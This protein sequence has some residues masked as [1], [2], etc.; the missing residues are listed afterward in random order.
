MRQGP[1]R[2]ESAP[3]PRRSRVLGPV[4]GHCVGR[5]SRHSAGTAVENS[6]PG[7]VTQIR[8][9]PVH[10]VSGRCLGSRGAPRIFSRGGEH[11]SHA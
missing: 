3:S 6:P 7:T 11:F 1:V 9:A 8:V 10:A 5:V 4:I 2:A